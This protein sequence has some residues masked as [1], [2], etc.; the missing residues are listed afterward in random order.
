MDK[1]PCAGDRADG[2][3]G[4]WLPYLWAAGF[5]LVL[6]SL[7]S[8]FPHTQG[9][10]RINY[11]IEKAIVREE[12]LSYE[13]GSWSSYDLATY[14]GSQ[15]KP[16]LQLGLADRSVLGAEDASVL[17]LS[18]STSDVWDYHTNSGYYM[19]FW[20]YEYNFLGRAKGDSAFFGSLASSSYIVTPFDEARFLLVG[21]TTTSSY[22]LEASAPTEL[23]TRATEALSFEKRSW[24]IVVATAGGYAAC[25]WDHLLGKVVCSFMDHNLSKIGNSYALSY[26]DNWVSMGGSSDGALNILSRGYT[27]PAL[28]LTRVDAN[29]APS[30]LTIS[31]P[32][33]FSSNPIR[34]WA[35]DRFW[36]LEGH[37][38]L[39]VSSEGAIEGPF[40]SSLDFSD[41]SYGLAALPDGGLLV[42][43]PL[44]PTRGN[45]GG[46]SP[47]YAK[48]LLQLWRLGDDLSVEWKRE[49]LTDRPARILAAAG[50]GLGVSVFL[51]VR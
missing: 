16:C 28:A 42:Y 31:L 11:A 6:V 10:T 1:A 50:D 14:S 33:G 51:C 36:L 46:V 2:S 20:P 41:A 49:W 26:G 7:S 15:D 8:C 43:G 30:T 21:D 12:R 4:K 29:T 18:V 9:P 44:E 23:G 13:D 38:A 47:P 5:C 35:G 34:R 48:A 40:T 32:E 39:S 17:S 22:S 25:A 24:P 45:E 27:D 3:D 19:S 37:T